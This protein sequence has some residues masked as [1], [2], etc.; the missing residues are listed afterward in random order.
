MTSTRPERLLQRRL[1]RRFA[2]VGAAAMV[3]MLAGFQFLQPLPPGTIVIA[4]GVDGGLYHR[5]AQQYA[6]LLAE[7]GVRVV[8]R[9]TSGAAEN[10]ALLLDRTSGVDV[11]FLQGGVASMPEAEHLDMLASLY[12]EPLWIFYRGDARLGRINQLRGK[13]LAI[14][15]PGSGTNAFARPI[16]AANGITSANSAIH[17]ADSTEALR[18]LE[19]GEVD[20]V[21]LVGGAESPLIQRAL[22]EPAFR[23]LSLERAEAYT[24]RW[25]HI[26][27]LT[28]PPGAISFERNIPEDTVRLIGTK[29]MLVARDDVHPAIVNLL[30]DAAREIHGRQGIFEDG[31]EFPGT[32]RVDIPVSSYADQHRRFGPSYFYQVLP[33]WAAALVE[34]AIILLIPLLVVLVPLMNILPRMVRWRD[35]S[36]LVRWYGRLALLERDV[37]TRKRDDAPVDKWLQELAEISRAVGQRR[38][39]P[40]FASEVFTLREHIDLVR[41][42]ILAKH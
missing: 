29:A 27:Q 4:S 36:R 32:A 21:F 13:R 3:A 31:G 30:I 17:Q 1:V 10:Y 40:A 11:A 14:G 5:Y 6:S 12:I 22:F 34:R 38:M 16:L 20:A 15:A 39:P 35:R 37:A 23:L 24:R 28:L 19:A 7:H 42:E 9:Q 25:P 2:I 26:E 8:E 18:Q 41:R 33:F